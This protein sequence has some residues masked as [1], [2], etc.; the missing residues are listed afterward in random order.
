MRDELKRLAVGQAERFLAS[1]APFAVHFA[2]TYDEQ[3]GCFGVK[4]LL[5]DLRD[6]GIAPPACIVGEP[7]SM[8]PAIAHKGVHRWRFAFEPICPTST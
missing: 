3:T 5:A 7:T 4:E 2:F 1:D 8:A 6:A